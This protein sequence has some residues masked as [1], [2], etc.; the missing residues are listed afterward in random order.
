MQQLFFFLNQLLVCICLS[1][2]HT[3]MYA[4]TCAYACM[5]LGTHVAIGEQRSRMALSIDPMGPRHQNRVGRPYPLNCLASP[6]S[7]VLTK[8]VAQI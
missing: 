4:H 8:I 1:L 6:Q 7:N 2:T 3:Y 5:Y